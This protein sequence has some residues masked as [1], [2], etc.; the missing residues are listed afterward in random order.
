MAGVIAPG[1]ALRA[2]LAHM[3]GP[4]IWGWADCCTG[5]CDVFRHLHGI[6]PM[7]PLRGTYQCRMGALRQIAARGGWRDMTAALAAEAGLK[8]G[9]RG[10]G[11]LGLVRIGP[12]RFD[13][14]LAVS[15]APGV[16]QAKAPDGV[17][18][19]Y[20]AVTAWHA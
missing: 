3:R 1:D 4:F 19:R 2:V 12:G 10:A 11:D 14:A 15:V 5:A 8:D 20:D 16:W 18:R 6:D 9:H 13:M 17:A 7:A